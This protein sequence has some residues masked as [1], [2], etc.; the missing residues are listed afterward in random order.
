[1]TLEREGDADANF[2][3]DSGSEAGVEGAETPTVS[4]KKEGNKV[5]RIFKAPFKAFGKLF[6]RKDD[7]K[8]Q[9]MTEE[10]AEE[11]RMVLRRQ[12]SQPQAQPGNI[13]RAVEH[14][15]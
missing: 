2:L 4:K 13:S 14:F 3:E 1:M 12:G 6:G 8:L 7:S 15:Y 11:L 10:D 5:A 9:R